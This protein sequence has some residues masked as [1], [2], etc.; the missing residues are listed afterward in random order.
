MLN[1]NSEKEQK[2]KGMQ[3]GDFDFKYVLYVCKVYSFI[4]TT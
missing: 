2:S 3:T 1:D 4:K